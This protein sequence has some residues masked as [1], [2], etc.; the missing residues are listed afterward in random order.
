MHARNVTDALIETIYACLLGEGSW[1]DFLH[2]Y[3]Q[4]SPGCWALLHGAGLQ[5]DHADI[6]LAVGRDAKDIADYPE[7]HSDNPWAPPYIRAPIGQ[8]NVV[9]RN[10]PA[11]ILLRSSFYNELLRPIDTRSCIGMNIHRSG[12]RMLTLSL[13]TPDAKEETLLPLAKEIARLAPHLARASDFYRR[14]RFSAHASELGG[15]LFEAIHVGVVVVGHGRRV[16]SCSDLAQRM[17]GTVISIDPVARLRISD[18]AAQTLLDGM[19]SYHYDGPK[20]QRVIVDRMRISMV[21]MEIEREHSLFE[22]PGVCLMIE[23]LEAAGRFFDHDTFVARYRLSQAES[24]VLAGIISGK[25]I[26]EIA[27]AADRSQETVRSQVKSIYQKTGTHGAAE[28]LRFA[29]GM[30]G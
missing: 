20:A 6:A 18:P 25:S 10:V 30:T 24:R 12:G 3:G 13:M 5:D 11:D 17:F 7:Y 1:Q 22:G 28:L 2:L 15:S 21:R 27:I 8:V 16:R 14:T 19:L 9:E 4:I 29:I 26:A 23:A